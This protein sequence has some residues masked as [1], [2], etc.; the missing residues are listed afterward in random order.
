MIND[1]D[2]KV[3]VFKIDDDEY[4][5][6]VEQV[7]RI[8]ENETIT[9]IPDSP[10]FLVGVINYQGRI[11]PIIDLK[12]RF[13]LNSKSVNQNSKIIL[14]KD[15]KGDIGLIIDSVSQIV[16]ISSDSISEPPDVISGIIKKYIKA[17]IKLD[18]KIIIY[19]N[20]S[21]ILE[22][23]EKNNINELVKNS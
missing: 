12:K 7:E 3:V 11:I 18:K 21:E 16:D 22:F 8:L 20:L 13:N 10:E 9:K 6:S 15:T 2:K 17:I 5:T 19:I 14:A 4:A 23:S 1:K